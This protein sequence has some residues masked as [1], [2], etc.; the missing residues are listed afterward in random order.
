MQPVKI[1]VIGA[2][3]RGTTYAT[4]AEKFPAKAKV[5]GVA[6]PRDFYRETFSQKHQ[7]PLSNISADWVTL[8]EKEKFADA[9]FIT[10]QDSLHKEPAIAFANKGYHILLEKPMAPNE[11]DCRQITEAAQKNNKLF[12][13]CHILR[14]NKYTQSI[15]TILDAGT[16]GDV[17]TIQH[18]EPVGYWHQAHSYVRGNWRNE[19]IASFMLLTKSCHDLDWLSYIVGKKWVSVSSFASLKHFRKEEKPNNAGDRCLSCNCE[20]NCPYSAKKIYFGRLKRRIIGWP[21]NILT[22]DVTEENLYEALRSGP[23]GRCVYECDNDVVDHQ[24]VNILF[25]DDVTV[26]FTMTAFN[27]AVYR[28]TYIFGTRGELFCDGKII[29]HYDFLTDRT[30]IITPELPE[31]QFMNG[32]GGGDYE[33][34]KAFIEAI[35]ENDASKIRSGPQET[36]ESHLLVFAA[37]KARLENKVVNF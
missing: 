27:E 10:T 7:I 33:L 18:L 32:H 5:V 30:S 3:D 15:K 9:V 24:V 16:I 2:G 12:A 11:E 17:V 28:K 35:V 26:S 8:A 22:P 14:Y 29:R 4:Y 25:E 20:P 34:I 37:E 23:Y 21:V 6:E 19:K 1:I 31:Y 13:V 36:L